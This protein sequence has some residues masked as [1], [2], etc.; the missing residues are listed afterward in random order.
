LSDL[1]DAMIIHIHYLVYDERKPF[2]YLDFMNFEVDGH[3]FKMSHGTFRNNISRLVREGLVE[4]SYRSNIAFYTLRCVKFGKASRIAMTDNHMVV[5]LSSNPVY[6]IIKDL[7]LE[8]NSVHDIRLKFHVP[9][10][11]YHVI[12][13]QINNPLLHECCTNPINKDIFLPVWQIENLDVKVVV[14]KTNTVSVIVG[15]SYSPIA[16]DITG[17]IRLTN[18]LVV[19]R[20]RLSALVSQGRR[21]NSSNFS[22]IPD[23]MEWIVTM[24]HFGADA[25][26]EYTGERFSATWGIAQD[27]I[28]RVYSK[29]M[30]D[31]RRRIRLERQEY[32]RITLALAL[33]QKI[34][35][36]NDRWSGGE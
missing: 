6:R 15:C 2:S 5:T 28:I 14:H 1:I 24:W 8:K 23:Y 11:Y 22:K 31:H 34:N 12:V 33:E 36:N 9:E 20:E 30:K 4:I 25:S 21:G 16:V 32:P 10:L 13:S 29:T 7:P 26:V 27:A 18:A 35:H 3:E 17:I 19:V